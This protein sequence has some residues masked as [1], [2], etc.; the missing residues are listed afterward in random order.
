MLPPDQ[1]YKQSDRK[2]KQT[3]ENRL[4]NWIFSF[5]RVAIEQLEFSIIEIIDIIETFLYLINH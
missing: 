2:Y 4:E 3:Y 1:K 5:P